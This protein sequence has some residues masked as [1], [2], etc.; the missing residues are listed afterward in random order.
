MGYR[1][2]A[3]KAQIVTQTARGL[4]LFLVRTCVVV[5]EEWPQRAPILSFP[6]LCKDLGLH[7][8]AVSSSFGCRVNL[9]ICLQVRGETH[10]ML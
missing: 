1:V 5:A 2:S 8:Q 3:K 10:M 7:T 9:A 6:K 4:D